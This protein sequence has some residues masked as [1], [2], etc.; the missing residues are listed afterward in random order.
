MGT[1][2]R[3]DCLSWDEYFMAVALLSGQRS[4]DPNTRVG[5][6]VADA[7]NKIVGVGY[8]GFPWGCSD[9]ELPWTREGK[10][11]ETKYPYVCHAELNAVLNATSRNLS[12]CR[13][14]VA[15]FPC[16]EC[17][18]VIIQSGIREIIYLSDKYKET[19]SVRASKIMLEKS[20]VLYRQFTSERKAVSLTF[21]TE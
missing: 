19:D 16:N 12:G 10:Y 4:K 11:L 6:C 21:R 7:D 2:K 20:G 1:G 9:D 8:N 17:T 14:Y 18:K 15:L 5:A 13:I 3:T